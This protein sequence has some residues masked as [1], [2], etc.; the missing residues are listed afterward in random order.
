MCRILAC[1]TPA[2]LAACSTDLCQPPRQV[3]APSSSTEPGSLQ[4]GQFQFEAAIRSPVTRSLAAGSDGIVACA[5]CS[6]IFSIDTS[7]HSIGSL[8]T[9]GVGGVVA[10][11]D[12]IY[13]KIPGSQLDTTDIVAF[14]PS[15]TPRWRSTLG[16]APESVDL[17]ASDD[18]VY[19][20]AVPRD[21]TSQ[22]TQRT[23]F[24]IDAATGAQRTVATGLHVIGPSHRGVIAVAL[25]D[26]RPQ[27]TVQQIDPDGNV[28]WSHSI[29]STLGPELASTLATADGLVAVFGLV[30]SDVDLGERTIPIVNIN[31]ENGFV[32]AFDATG[33]TQWA[34]PVDSGGVTHVAT[35]PQGQLLVAS[36]RQVGGG[37]LSPEIDTYLSVATT[38]GVVRSLTIDG[39]G[40]QEIRGLAA[41]PDG[42]AWI[43]VDNLITSDSENEPPAILQVSGKHF[44]EVGTYLF[45]IVP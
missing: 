45:K 38:A 12:A 9:R 19:V 35:T 11:D 13:A 29:Q 24:A 10:H 15:G 44:P 6:G 37:L 34:F 5:T 16:T 42:T 26:S 22:L 32:A 36:Q 28:V 21:S 27:R 30:F 20:S 3:V 33:A 43:Q 4:F 31:R 1:V 7:Y 23:L 40:I 18:S 14:S 39:V 17:I 8:D 2:I 41:A 25:S